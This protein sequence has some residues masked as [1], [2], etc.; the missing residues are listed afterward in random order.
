MVS[1]GPSLLG[2]P[3]FKMPFSWRPEWYL[4]FA[5]HSCSQ[6]YLKPAY[7]CFWFL[8]K[9]FSVSSTYILL[10]ALNYKQYIIYAILSGF[11]YFKASGKIVP[12]SSKIL[13]PVLKYLQL[14]LQW[15][16]AQ[17]F[18]SGIGHTQSS[19]MWQDR[20]DLQN[21]YGEKKKFT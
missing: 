6:D 13:S 1:R 9:C 5:F 12:Y 3:D 15:L 11:K 20:N 2:Q 4:M 16:D 17:K 19:P 8:F 21:F 7:S 18:N 14:T 10:Y